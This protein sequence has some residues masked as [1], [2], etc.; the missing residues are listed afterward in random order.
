MGIE[1]ILAL[2]SILLVILVF[3]LAS[4]VYHYKTKYEELQ[5]SVDKLREE[6]RNQL[7]E[8]IRRE[9]EVK[10]QRWLAEYE[11]K[12]RKDAIER[13][14][15]VILGRVGEQLALLII[16]TSLGVDPRDLRFLGSPVDYIA[17]KGLSSGNPQEILFIEVK[18]GKIT[19]LTEKQRAIKRLVEERK[20][21]QITLNLREKLEKLAKKILEESSE[22][23]ET[24]R[25]QGTR[26]RHVYY[27][28]K[29]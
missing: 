3:Y 9:Y 25:R 19:S 29:L 18:Y 2:V 26:T 21:K 5:H 23:Y 7:E 24:S 20:P 4:L 27:F 10:F 17:F 28:E 6:I 12:I 11:E 22:T 8:S 13:S 1:L 14:I 15:A 16:F